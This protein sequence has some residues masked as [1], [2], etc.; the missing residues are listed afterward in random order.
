MV[1]ISILIAVILVSTGF[2]TA[3]RHANDI[4]KMSLIMTFFVS[5]AVASL[6]FP[7]FQMSAH[8]DFFAVLASLRYGTQSLA[9]NVNGDIA[10]SLNLQQPLFSVYSILLYLLYILGPVCASI[11][12]IGFSRS[13]VERIR[14]LGAEHVH[15]FSELNERTA[16]VALSLSKT[17]PGSLRIFCSSDNASEALKIKARASHSLLVRHDETKV[18][19]SRRRKYH[20]Y[21]IFDN[22]DLTLKHT[23]ELVS[24]LKRK[25]HTANATIRVFVSHAQLELVRNIDRKNGSDGNYVRIRYIDE[26]QAEAVELFNRMID[27]LPVDPSG[28][29]Y[30]LLIV[31]CGECGINLFRT[32]AWLLV[33]PRSTYT[34][35]VVDKDA[36]RIASKLKEECPEFLNA[37]LEDYFRKE[38]NT[39]NYDIIFHEIDAES[40]AF[41]RLLE[42]IKTPDLSVCAVKEDVLNHRTAVRLCRHYAADSDT[43]S[44]PPI[45][46][47]MRS[48]DTSDL[49]R[50][51]SWADQES[52]NAYTAMSEHAKI[53]YF[54]NLETHYDYTNLIHP[55][56]E[57]AAKVIHRSYW[58]SSEWTPE[59]ET[60]F[61]RY[62]NYDSSFAQALAMLI[63]R[64]YILSSK[65]ESE[66]PDAWIRNRLDDEEY[67][68]FLGDA[69]HDRWNAY[70]RINGWRCAGLEQVRAIAKATA[71][72]NVKDDSLLLHPAIVP[73]AQLAQREKDVDAI[74]RE[75]DP[76]AKGVN[77]VQVDRFIIRCLP[78]IL[79]SEPIKEQ[80]KK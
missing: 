28:Y 7:Y 56:L 60:E 21:E 2:I 52:E 61:Y 12:F 8:N 22:P 42:D 71:G 77:Y 49:I 68:A 35:H 32:A 27:L 65:P 53:F 30:T 70:Q 9:M 80:K 64:R 66:N 20:F 10:Y 46:A 17:K 13:L 76:N 44:A 14:M 43:L 37:P 55:E 39:K 40:A 63:R 23:S 29:H 5:L 54:G 74:R 41:T 62:V 75:F 1:I 34:I 78:D 16:E 31:G 25:N 15:V 18:R 79:K 36:R 45:V 4:Q 59:I 73:C 67:L 33:L 72:R 38:G 58:N 69:E 57:E 11:F 47:R 48:K 50:E 19:M 26:N 6:A 24:V 3:G 51:Q